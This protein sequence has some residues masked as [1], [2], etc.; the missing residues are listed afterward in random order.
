LTQSRT[1]DWEST[2]RTRERQDQKLGYAEIAALLGACWTDGSLHAGQG[3]VYRGVTGDG[4][5]TRPHSPSDGAKNH[6][7]KQTLLEWSS[8]RRA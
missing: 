7:I 5:G 3:L 2:G 1:E 4:G 8:D 6:L